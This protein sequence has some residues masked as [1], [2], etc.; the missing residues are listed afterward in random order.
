MSTISAITFWL[1][2]GLVIYTYAAYPL[3]IWLLGRRT[4]RETSPEDSFPHLTLI[5]PAHNEEAWIRHKLEN[6]LELDYPR[7]LLRI[8]VASDG[9]ADCTVEIA[10]QFADRGVEVAAF[11]ERHGKQEML[12]LLAA[13]SR[14]EILVM[15]DTHVLLQPDSVRML[16]RHFSDPQI[17]C[18]TG[19]RL[20]IL[21]PGVPQGAGEGLYWR[22]ES[23]IKQSESRVHSCLG[24]HGQLYAVRRSVFPRVERV[25]EDF[26]I[27]MK[28]I[29]ATGMRVL[30]EPQ[31]RTFTPA[32]ASLAIEFERKTRAHVSFLLTLSLLPEL[33]RPR[34]NPVGW[35]YVSHHLLRMAVPLGLAAMLASA[36][37][38]A[39][40]HRFFLWAAVT[41]LG[42]YALAAV[43]MVLAR[44]DIRLKIFYLPFYFTFANLAIDHP[45][46]RSFRCI[47]DFAS[48]RKKNFPPLE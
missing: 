26:Y 24:A 43:G 18:V 29:A 41:Q 23:W 47:Y 17:G 30:Y 35:Q 40:G 2:L 27:P 20:C 7:Q 42:F 22:Y 4:R 48:K 5:I 38:L 13:E 16:V 9:S 10:R 8:V 28:I 15:T 1:S 14:S 36:C 45:L 25:G 31:A 33:L 34:G 32:A 46:Y 6:T 39:P 21:Q 11:A 44:L 3:L 12:D 19:Q 37:L